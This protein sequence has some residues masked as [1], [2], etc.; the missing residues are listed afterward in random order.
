MS[1]ILRAIFHAAFGHDFFEK[2]L[3]LEH[4]DFQKLRTFTL[5]LNFHQGKMARTK[6]PYGLSKQ[7]SLIRKVKNSAYNSPIIRP[8]I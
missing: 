8:S 3:E 5:V 4:L 6:Q 1:R 2:F 7:I